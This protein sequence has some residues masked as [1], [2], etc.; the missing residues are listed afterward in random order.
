MVIWDG[1]DKHHNERTR[2]DTTA[3]ARFTYYKSESGAIY[4][5]DSEAPN[6]PPRVWCPAEMLTA[7]LMR[8]YQI[9]NR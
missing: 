2:Y 9:K 7:H 5:T 4:Y 6:D 1:Y 3:D 8:L